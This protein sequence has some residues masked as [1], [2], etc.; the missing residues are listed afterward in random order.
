M[1]NAAR[2]AADRIRARRRLRLKVLAT[3]LPGAGSLERAIDTSQPEKVSTYRGPDQA[4]KHSVEAEAPKAGEVKQFEPGQESWNP[5]PVHNGRPEAELRVGR[6]GG[7]DKAPT[8]AKNITAGRV[9]EFPSKAE[10]HTVE[11]AK[12]VAKDIVASKGWVA[13]LRQLFHR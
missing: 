2:A 10:V 1:T 7:D 12:T 9:Y 11:Q 5:D 8:V 13:W 6:E 4:R 3:S